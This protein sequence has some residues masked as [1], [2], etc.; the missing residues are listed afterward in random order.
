M[1]LLHPSELENRKVLV[2]GLGTFGGGVG[3]A[4]HLAKLGARVVATD[5]RA[6]EELGTAAAALTDFGVNLRLGGHDAAMFERAEV[7]VVDVPARIDSQ[8]D[9]SVDRFPYGLC[10]ELPAYG[11]LGEAGETE[12]REGQEKRDESG[13]GLMGCLSGAEDTADCRVWKGP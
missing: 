9:D 12:G 11:V 6:A 8:L 13:H 7:V 10:V 3:A 1:T 5:L 4:R 2:L